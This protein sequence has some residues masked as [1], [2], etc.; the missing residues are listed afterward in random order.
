MSKYLLLALFGMV[1]CN[2]RFLGVYGIVAPL[3]DLSPLG[4][5]LEAEYDV[6]KVDC[7]WNAPCFKERESITRLRSRGDIEVARHA[8]QE[9]RFSAF[10][11]AAGAGE[12]AI[13]TDEFD[14]VFEI[15]IEP[16]RYSELRWNDS[17]GRPRPLHRHALRLEQLGPAFSSTEIELDQIHYRKTRAELDEILAT[18]T[19]PGYPATDENYLR[20]RTPWKLDRGATHAA[21][22]S[23]VLLDIDHN[24][25]IDVLHTGPVLGAATLSTHVGGE[26]AVEIVDARAIRGLIALDGR[27]QRIEVLHRMTWDKRFEV[28]PLDAVGRMIAGC[29]AD[30]PEVFDQAGR[31]TVTKMARKVTG[32]RSPFC[33]FEFEPIDKS[34]W[35]DTAIIVRWNGIEQRTPIIDDP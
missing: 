23:T 32:R 31:Y 1:G 2:D 21:L 4:E 15:P 34:A 3:E 9:W 25:S 26:L 10:G 22:S 6:M 5:G 19:G 11:V 16:I 7:G 18:D 14:D 27:A 29:P 33:E 13:E 30:G 28:I 12:V 20:G 35:Q 17:S 24:R 8:E